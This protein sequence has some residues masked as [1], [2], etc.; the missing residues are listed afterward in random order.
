MESAI[1]SRVLRKAIYMR[2]SDRARAQQFDAALRIYETQRHALAG[3]QSTAR[4][5]TFLEQLVESIRR[6]E[7]ISLIR[8]R[9]ISGLR[10]NSLSENFDPLKAAVLH[11]Q[12]GN[13]DEAFWLVFLSV[14][15]GRHGRD[16]WRLARDVYAGPKSSATWDWKRMASNVDGFRAWLATQTVAWKADG[17]TRRFGNHHK[18]QSLDAWA[19]NG[20]GA[21]IESYVEWVRPHRTHRGLVEDAQKTVGTAPRRVFDYL[22]RSMDAVT[23]FGRT[24]KFDYL[25][26]AGK[27]GLAAVEPGSPYLKGATGPLAGARLLFADDTKARLP[28]SIMEE[29]VTQLGDDLGVGMQVLEDSLCNWQKSPDRFRPFRG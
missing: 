15:F 1:G 21:A 5:T 22:Y 3:I 9:K 26:M 27:L 4:R 10:G 16:G 19:K 6:I 29:R 17:V 18:Y 24:A 8:T 25:T 28:A 23:S 14:H 11:T 13:I 20:T 2:P 7:Y 12:Q